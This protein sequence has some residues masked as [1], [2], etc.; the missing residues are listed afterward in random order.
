MRGPFGPF[1]ELVHLR[2]VLLASLVHGAV[3]VG[4]G[5]G[6]RVCVTPPLEVVDVAILPSE[7]MLELPPREPVVLEAVDDEETTDEAFSE[8]EVSPLPLPPQPEPEP[9]VDESEAVFVTPVR[10]PPS[11]DLL[12]RTKRKAEREPVAP[13][14]SESAS[15]SAP[16]VEAVALTD[17]NKPPRYPRLAQRL[18]VE[19]EVVLLVTVGVDGAVVRVDVHES[20]GLTAAHKALNRA[21]IAALVQW[22]YTPARRDGEPVETVIKVPVRFRLR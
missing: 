9:V 19:G 15:E 8:I 22:R 7:P 4:L 12:R 13:A 10:I 5:L 1:S 21:A 11:A 16:Y 20:A 17:R 18:G 14:P 6:I 3:L 2:S